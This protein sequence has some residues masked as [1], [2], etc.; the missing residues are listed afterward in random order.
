MDCYTRYH[1]NTDLQDRFIS[2]I[3]YHRHKNTQIQGITK[4]QTSISC[5][6]LLKD[7]V[8]KVFT[9]F[10]R[11]MKQKCLQNLAF[12]SSAFLFLLRPSLFH[13]TRLINSF[14]F[15]TLFS[16]SIHPL[17]FLEKKIK[18]IHVNHP[19]VFEFYSP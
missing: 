18:S 10:S 1:C 4:Y 2:N 12:S 16:T 6:I 19:P 11:K 13:N 17:Y 9:L 8:N 7:I 15:S 5:L 14:S 3:L